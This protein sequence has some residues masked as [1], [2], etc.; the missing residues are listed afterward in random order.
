MSNN[1]DEKICS[2]V[3]LITQSR[4]SELQFDRTIKGIVIEQR[5]LSTGEY[6]IQYQDGYFTAY[7]DDPIKY[8]YE[9]GDSVYIKIPLNNFE[10]RKTILGLTSGDIK[11]SLNH[12]WYS[13]SPPSPI[14]KE[15]MENQDPD[16][17]PN[18]S[19][20]FAEKGLH[21]DDL[22]YHI[23]TVSGQV[24]IYKYL[25]FIDAETNRYR[26]VF[27]DSSID[28][29]S[30]YIIEYSIN[31]IMSDDSNW[32]SF[33]EKTINH[34][35]MRI[36]YA[37][38]NNNI[39]NIGVWS[40]PIRIAGRQIDRV[41]INIIPSSSSIAYDETKKNPQP[42]EITF[43]AEMFV[44]TEPVNIL[45]YYW[46]VPK[47]ASGGVFIPPGGESPDNYGNPV[48]GPSY[49]VTI[50]SGSEGRD[51]GKSY[52]KLTAVT[53]GGITEREIFFASNIIP[54]SLRGYSVRF[55]Y[56]KNNSSTTPPTLSS[57]DPLPQGTW[58]YSIPPINSGE[59]IWTS[60]AQWG[61]ISP[62]DN[63]HDGFVGPWSY[64]PVRFS[65]TNGFNGTDAYSYS[66]VTNTNTIKKTANN[67]YIPSTINCQLY[68][69]IG[70]A[71]R[72]GY[73]G[74]FRVSTST[75]GIAYTIKDT[76]VTDVS[77][78]VYPEWLDNVVS[79]KIEAFE[80]GGTTVKIEEEIIPILLD[81]SDVLTVDLSNDSH[82][83]PA[84][85]TGGVT[86]YANSG[87]EIHIYQGAEEL[88]Y[89]GAGATPGK[90]KITSSLGTNITVGNYTDS[91]T[92]VTVGNA[93]GFLDN[94]DT[95]SIVYNVSGQR[96]N[97]ESFT[98]SK[99]QS[100]SKSKAGITGP[101]GQYQFTCYKA[102]DA[103][104]GSIPSSEYNATSTSDL[105]G[106][107]R[108]VSGWYPTDASA[109]IA[110]TS[111]NWANSYLYK[112]WVLRG[113]ANA[114]HSIIGMGPPNLL[115]FTADYIKAKVEIVTPKIYS[116]KTT[117]DSTAAGYH[118]T[119]G[120]N[121]HFG[122]SKSSLKWT[123]SSG[124][125]I[126]N[127]VLNIGN[128]FT[129]EKPK[130]E[131][132]GEVSWF[133]DKEAVIRFSDELG[134]TIGGIAL[135][136]TGNQ[137]NT[138]AIYGLQGFDHSI[139]FTDPSFGRTALVFNGDATF[140]GEVIFSGSIY[141]YQKG[142]VS[143]TPGASNYNRTTFI[144]GDPSYR[145]T[146][147]VTFEEGRFST[148]PMVLVSTT[149]TASFGVHVTPTNISSSGFTIDI[150]KGTSTAT[151]VNW[152]AFGL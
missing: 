150:T 142:N 57:G 98:V 86:S 21:V 96:L 84:N 30:G 18:E 69:Q 115:Q 1:I 58:S 81:G 82:T 110:K 135:G 75:D 101:M 27:V 124:L 92:F 20:S 123:S 139:E 19:W 118:I 126:N 33:E 37:G 61:Y 122:D 132:E 23:D 15:E 119:S 13:D 121:A 141:N 144:A 73:K 116:G 22:Y 109:M 100:F 63:V 80:E 12:Y 137:I 79:I 46:E 65:G 5:D 16:G 62:D 91:G 60:S 64:P 133:A 59:Y 105:G 76:S 149:E 66:L 74:R 48:D 94:K 95:A 152:V 25:D 29:P 88:T 44:N 71:S 106:G 134:A 6:L 50:A 51:I 9:V 55:I 114:D 130:S 11:A 72:I 2:A 43:T 28:S 34:I 87:T 103:A 102:F 38:D 146:T 136:Q 90:W 67:T 3:D 93:S 31:G 99:Q 32:V 145:G 17:P 104:S 53:S 128:I 138:F 117:F 83:F 85:A 41:K 89:D 4:I 120:G 107:I 68:K 39:T 10:E 36:K 131:A 143:I 7:A 97:G 45:E 113:Q 14:D 151:S 49:T 140:N 129:I 77:S 70:T 8:L 108:G 42:S 56:A 78:F 125:Q 111:N 24:Y 52:I 147:P 54:Q 35:Y 26:W 148:T 40:P 47:S 112:V 127:G